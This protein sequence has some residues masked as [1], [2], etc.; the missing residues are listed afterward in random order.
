M[1]KTLDGIASEVL[2]KHKLPGLFSYRQAF[3]LGYNTRKQREY[4]LLYGGRPEAIDLLE[5]HL[6]PVEEVSNASPLL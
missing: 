4:Q 5:N 1:S 6:D 2:N 3:I